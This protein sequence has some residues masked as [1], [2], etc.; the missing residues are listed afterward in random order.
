MGVLLTAG[1]PLLPRRPSDAERPRER[2]RR[3]SSGTKR[4]RRPE[5]KARFPQIWPLRFSPCCGSTHVWNGISDSFGFSDCVV[6]KSHVCHVTDVKND[7]ESSDAPSHAL[8]LRW[9][10]ESRFYFGA[11]RAVVIARVLQSGDVLDSRDVPKCYLSVWK[12]AK[13]N[14]FPRLGSHET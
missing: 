14:I 6:G 13:T 10:L 11:V 4:T 2:A 9:H 3:R 1:Q 8:N 7:A 5:R 12:R